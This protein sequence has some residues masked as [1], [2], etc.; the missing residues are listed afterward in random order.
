MK[1]WGKVLKDHRIQHD[2]VLAFGQARPSDLSG[3]S[4]VLQA[5]CKPLDLAQPVMLKKHLNE[6]TQFGRT[7]F[8]PSDFLESVSFDR[9]EIELFPEKKEKPSV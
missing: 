4:P 1:I 9:F 8:L 2:A 7:V 3:W 5:L 6:L